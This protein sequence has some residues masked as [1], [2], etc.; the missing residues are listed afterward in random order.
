MSGGVTVGGDDDP[1]S[2]AW[3]WKVA[4]LQGLSAGTQAS[5]R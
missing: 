4:T 1:E 3:E 2:V 5:V